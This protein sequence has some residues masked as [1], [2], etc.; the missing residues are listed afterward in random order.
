MKKSALRKMS[1]AILLLSAVS[2]PAS[3]DVSPTPQPMTQM[4]QFKRDRDI[5]NAAIRERNQKIR[6][7]NQIFNNA[8]KKARID[9]K[10]SM[11]SALKPEEKSAVNANLKSVIT[12]AII[13]RESAIFA[14]GEPPMPPIEPPKQQ[15]GLQNSKNGL[16]KS[17]R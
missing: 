15:K 14:L 16:E 11:E 9:S 7:I 10:I 6:N 2:F 13:A 4:E 1:G 17:R 12:A 8:I 5:Y 3:A